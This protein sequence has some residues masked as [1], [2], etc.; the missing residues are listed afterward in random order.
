MMVAG[1]FGAASRCRLFLK[2]YPKGAPSFSPRI[3]LG[4]LWDLWEGHWKNLAEESAALGITSGTRRIRGFAE[5]EP[6]AS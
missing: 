6:P 4:G 1:G 2:G 3:F 5:H